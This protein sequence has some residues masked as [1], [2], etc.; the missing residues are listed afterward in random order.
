M[1]LTSRARKLAKK[2]E[3]THQQAVEEIRK[4]GTK[5]AELAKEYGWELWRADA[6]AIDP[7]LDDGYAVAECSRGARYV[8]IRSCES[9]CVGYFV[10]LDKKGERVH[11]T[12]EHCES[13]ASGIQ[14]DRCG[15]DLLKEWD[16]A[17]CDECF[18][19]ALR[20]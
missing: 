15:R 20:E 3:I 6:Y 7:S 9:C 11:G 19:H 14:C 5:P 10:A 1:S 13:C 8:E 16:M 12:E 18:K 4:L 2:M 17:V